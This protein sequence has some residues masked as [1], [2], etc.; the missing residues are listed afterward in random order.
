M[1]KI[2]LHLKFIPNLT[3]VMKIHDTATVT[4]ECQCYYFRDF[5]QFYVQIQ[6]SPYFC[7]TNIC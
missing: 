5:L 1:T 3:S 2:K 4:S 6:Y 7:S